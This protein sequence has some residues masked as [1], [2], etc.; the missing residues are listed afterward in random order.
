M[1]PCPSSLSLALVL[2]LVTGC[3][4]VPPL[5]EELRAERGTIVYPKLIPAG[6]IT[7]QVPPAATDARSAPDLEERAARLRARAARLSGPAIDAE[8]RA[9][10]ETGIEQ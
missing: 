7:G 8:T 4:E 3:A 10:M 5:S 1:R 6:E 2:V 9:R